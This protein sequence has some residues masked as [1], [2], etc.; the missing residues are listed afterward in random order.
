MAPVPIAQTAAGNYFGRTTTGKGAPIPVNP[1]TGQIDINALIGQM[2]DRR[3]T[4]IYDTWTL[5]PGSTVTNTPINFFQT[6]IGQPDPYNGN[7][8]KTPLE[9]N[10]RSTG[11][12]NPPYDMIL[13]NLGFLFVIGNRLFDIAQIVNHGWF[14]F[15]I[16]EKTMWMGHLWRHPPGAGFSGM[17]TQTTESTWN[18]GI[19]SPESIWPFGNYRKYIP[20]LVNFSCTLNF[21]ETYN[22]MYNSSLPAWITA[23]LGAIGASLPTIS[24]AGNGGNGIKLIAFMNGLSDG[25][26]Q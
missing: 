3:K 10:M 9:T 21:P 7:V 23:T 12:F 4:Y 5:A 22:T 6:P 24:T 11:Q 1:N 13:F 2:V 20:P 19:P 14:E 17:S 18:N 15:K 25:P 26:V 8:P 16:L